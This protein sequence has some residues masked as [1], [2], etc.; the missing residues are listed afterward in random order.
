MPG[1][2]DREDRAAR[3]SCGGSQPSRNDARSRRP[4]RHGPARLR[5]PGLVRAAMMPGHED[6]ED[7]PELGQYGIVVEAA[8]MPGHEDREDAPIGSVS[9][10]SSGRRNDA[11]SRRPGRPPASAGPW[12]ASRGRNDARSRRP[13]RRRAPTAGRTGVGRA[14]MMPGHED[15]EDT[16]AGRLGRAA[17]VPP[18]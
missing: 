17:P 6:R 2:E 3:S 7:R 13:G 11:R 5:Q 14:A 9:R 4:G 1:H 12:P 18:Q 10:R 8:M 16:E 15:R